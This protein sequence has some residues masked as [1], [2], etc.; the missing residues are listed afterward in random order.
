MGALIIKLLIIM[1]DT[2]KEYKVIMIF[3]DPEIIRVCMYAKKYSDSICTS[4]FSNWP[5]IE[6]TLF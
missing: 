5:K 6:T 4:R 1:S 3:A 2:F